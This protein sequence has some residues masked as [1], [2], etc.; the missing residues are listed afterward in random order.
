MW[1]WTGAVSAMVLCYVGACFVLWE[2]PLRTD[3]I[4][5]RILRAWVL[6]SLGIAGVTWW[7]IGE[8]KR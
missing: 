6:A 1:R 4:E 2:F 3:A 8:M 7:L 5:P